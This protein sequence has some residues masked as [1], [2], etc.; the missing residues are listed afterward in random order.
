MIGVPEMSPAVSDLASVQELLVQLDVDT[1]LI[2]VRRIGVAFA[3]K[4]KTGANILARSFLQMNL[5]L[6]YMYSM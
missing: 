3:G 5:A 2:A 6:L 4:V 1:S